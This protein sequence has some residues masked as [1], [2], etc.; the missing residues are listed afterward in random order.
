[1]THLTLQFSP[2]MHRDIEIK[3]ETSH[4]AT[5]VGRSS[6]NYYS[7]FKGIHSNP[8]ILQSIHPMGMLG[9]FFIETF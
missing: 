7:I 4:I 2:I 5:S 8:Y 9:Y 3:E 6:K 1:M